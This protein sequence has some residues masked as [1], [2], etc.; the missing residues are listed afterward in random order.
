M[1]ALPHR[2]AEFRTLSSEVTR[3]TGKSW[4]QQTR[5][6]LALRHLGGQCG[7]TEYYDFKLYDPAYLRGRIDD[8]LG[9]R[10][11]GAF[12]RALNPRHAVL[13][14][15]DKVAFMQIAGGAGLPV[16]P[17]RACYHHAAQLPPSLGQHL[18]SPQ[19]VAEFLRHEARY[20]LFGKPAYS[21]QGYGSAYLVGYHA[22]DDSLELLGG[23]R[24]PLAR[25]LERLDTPVDRR[26]HRPACGFLFQDSLTLAPEIRALSGWPA[27]CGVRIC[28]LNGDDGVQPL[29][30]IWKVAVPPNQTDNFSLGK[31]GNLMLDIDLATGRVD[32][33]ITD[34]GPSAR[35]YPNHPFSGMALDGFVLP[36]WQRLLEIVHEA[37][38]IFPL[39][40]VHHW[41]FALTDQG[42]MILELNDLGGHHILQMHGHGLLTPST[43][44]FLKRYAIQDERHWVDRL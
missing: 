42:P 19:Q 22:Q 44:E 36:Q 7:L 31:Y 26:F 32:R 1:I 3:Q 30:A 34:L 2:I 35:L 33:A 21:Q 14:A 6:V 17:A 27:I 15:W 29:R 16:A 20:P 4:L 37:G 13:P 40:R 43:R 38:A 10:L 24:L 18:R 39:M 25:F 12:S 9:W 8:F 28:C 5:E 41:D 23:E 11:G